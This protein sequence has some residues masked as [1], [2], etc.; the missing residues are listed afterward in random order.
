MAFDRDRGTR[1]A[2]GYDQAWMMAR[3][4]ILARDRICRICRRA[5][6]TQVDH[7]V[8]LTRGGARLDPDNLQGLCAV[9]HSRK[10]ATEDS[11]FAMK[12]T[13]R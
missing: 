4:V 1:Q 5:E 9:C 6:S 7:I 2:R 11:R 8:P 3:M 13:R 10:T 12:G